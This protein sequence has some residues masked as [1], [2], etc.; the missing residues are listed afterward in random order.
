ML[1]RKFGDP[2]VLRWE[3]VPTPGPGEVIVQVHAV[4]VNRTL[5]EVAR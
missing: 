4:S 5:D 2:E 3:D 1:I